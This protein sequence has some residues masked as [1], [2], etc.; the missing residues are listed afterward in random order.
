[1]SGV[2]II[3]DNKVS[4]KKLET[5]NST[6]ISINGILSVDTEKY[7]ANSVNFDGSYKP[8]EDESLKI[9]NF[10]LPDE[11]KEAI[12]NP[13][14]VEKLIATDNDLNI[15]A[16]F[17]TLDDGEEGRIV[18]QRTQ[19]RQLLL[20]GRIT[21]FWNK[22][23]FISTKK[24]GVVITDSIDA[25]YENGTL[26]FKSYYLVNQIL[27][28]NKYYRQ[29]TDEDIRTFCQSSCFY[30]NDLDSLVSASNNWTRKKIAYILDTKVLETNSIDFILQDAKE[31]GLQFQT[32][33]ENKI[34]FPE[35]LKAQKELLSY[36]ADEIY[37]GR[38]TDDVY[39]TNS[40][41]TLK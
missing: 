27:N 40:K 18:F 11:I 5:D 25:Y 29:A 16:V 41:R 3:D 31:L 23:T 9:E 38:L 6:V 1:M 13:L 30:V 17:L 14:G 8:D 32:N 36:L 12:N 10:D 2:F 19:K 7:K 15:R 28:L 33:G 20:G 35:D 37:K 26:Y 4:I 34:V 22:D 39:L 24:P 21:L